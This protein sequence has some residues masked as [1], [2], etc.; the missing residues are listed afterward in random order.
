MRGYKC[1]RTRKSDGTSM[2]TLKTSA[3]VQKKPDAGMLATGEKNHYQPRKLREEQKHATGGEPK[4]LFKPG[5]CGEA[6]FL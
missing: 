6:C 1:R 5:D 4:Q 3:K 2:S